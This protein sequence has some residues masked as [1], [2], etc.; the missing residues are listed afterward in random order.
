MGI[1][2]D[3]VGDLFT[4][5]VWD[6]ATGNVLTSYKAPGS[7]GGGGGGGGLVVPPHC[8]DLVRDHYLLCTYQNSPTLHVWNLAK[9]DHL[10]AKMILPGVVTALAVSGDGAYCLA[11]IEAKIYIWQVSR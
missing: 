3:L 2:T 5:S 10:F 11:A 6:V 7:S 1:S 9:K 4:I 8:I